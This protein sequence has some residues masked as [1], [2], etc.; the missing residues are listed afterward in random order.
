M[1]HVWRA[2]RGVKRSAAREG[3][4]VR[5]IAGSGWRRLPR[6]I[7]RLEAKSMTNRLATRWLV[8]ALLLP[9]VALLG[10]STLSA[11]QQAQAAVKPP[12]HARPVGRLLIRNAM[13]I[14]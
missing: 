2:E 1:F 5:A 3:R 13:V 7:P 11:R 9:A 6:S 12:V 4:L 14:Y 8:V 10:P